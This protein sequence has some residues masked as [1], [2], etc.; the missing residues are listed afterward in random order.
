MN[1]NK[2]TLITQGPQVLEP[3]QQACVDV[4]TDALEEAIK[5]RISSVALVVCMD[6]GIGTTMAGM[7]GLALNIGCDDLK[8]KIHEA[9]FIDGNVA[10][11]R[12]SSILRAGR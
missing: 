1:G 6:D 2:P 11:K 7:N 12:K 8:K 5:G 9:I 3:M 4:L 10:S